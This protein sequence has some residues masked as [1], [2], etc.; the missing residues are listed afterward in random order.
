MFKLYSKAFL[1]FIGLLTIPLPLFNLRPIKSQIFNKLNRTEIYSKK[2]HLNKNFIYSNIENKDSLRSRSIEFSKV[3]RNDIIKNKNKFLNQLAFDKESEI[4][5]YTLEIESDLQY[6]IRNV[7]YAEGNAI[8]YFSNAI[9]KGD[10]IEYD[11]KNKTLKVLGDVVFKKGNQYFVAS[12]VFYNLKNGNGYIDNIYGVL[13]MNS[14]IEDFEFKNIKQK[15][16]L[17]NDENKVVGLEYIDSVN[18]GLVNDFEKTKKFNITSINFDIPSIKKWRYKSKK[19]ILEDK[20]L[21]SEDILFTNDALN[22]PQFFLKSKKFVGEIVDE[23]IKLISSKS[24][25][26]LDDKL[27]IPIGKRTIYDKEPISS[28]GIGSDYGDKDGFYLS[29]GFDPIEINDYLNFKFRPYILLQ[30]G[31]QGTT[32]AFRE[33]KSSLLSSKVNNDILLS[34]IFALDADINANINKWKFN[35]YTRLNTLNTNRLSESVRS[36]LVLE[37]SIDLNPKNDK[38]IN[39]FEEDI[40]LTNFVDIEAIKID[41]ENSKIDLIGKENFSEYLDFKY[42]SSFRDTISRG[43]SGEYEIYFGNS[44]SIAN[45]KSWI[46]K[47][48]KT[49]LALIFDT[50]QFK[51]KSK[52][53]NSF[54]NLYRNVFASKITYQLPLWKKKLLN[55]NINSEYKYSP[56]VINE[57]IEWVTDIQSGVFLYSDGSSQKGLTFSSG[58]NLVFGKFK[59]KFLD[60]TNINLRNSFVLKSGESPFGF[61]DINKSYRLNMN[62][63]Q[64]IYGP[65]VFSYETSLNFDDGKYSEPNYSIDIKRRAYSVGAFYNSSNKSLGL[66]FYIFNFNYLGQSEKF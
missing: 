37:K 55:K 29:K 24:S 7:Y 11:K 28:W 12:K 14:F 5:N 34:D 25:I 33:P 40:P 36:K 23:K 43:Y 60:Y 30:R 38:F 35:L 44:I 18:I 1:Y 45:R 21:F 10:K 51:A 41:N 46:N 15:Y 26:I 2:N 47:D 58:P 13:D 66:N 65:I 27:N 42:T 48:N 59:D 39:E 16:L 64:Q 9:L 31:I 56:K 50:G 52:H 17:K 49:Y 4:N 6:E 19:V 54:K 8:I 57:R 20:Q 53:I 22:K 32:N 62:I 3:F 61:D 63:Q